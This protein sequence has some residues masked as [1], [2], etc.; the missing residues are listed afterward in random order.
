[1]CVFGTR[2]LKIGSVRCVSLCFSL[3]LSFSFALLSTNQCVNLTS[4]FYFQMMDLFLFF[5]SSKN[6]TTHHRKC[7]LENT[8]IILELKYIYIYTL[9]AVYWQHLL[10]LIFARYQILLLHIYPITSHSDE[11]LKRNLDTL[12]SALTKP[13][14]Y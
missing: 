10:S 9:K 4:H 11:I 14:K 3:S 13:I 12:C 5:F 8:T 6:R 7:S 2:R 1:M